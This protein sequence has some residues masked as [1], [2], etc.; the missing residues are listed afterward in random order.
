MIEDVED[1]P[2]ELEFEALRKFGVFQHRPIKLLEVSQREHVAAQS[3]CIA[4][5][6]LGKGEAG[7]VRA[8]DRGA[9]RGVHAPSAPA[10]DICGGIAPCGNC[11][12]AVERPA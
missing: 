5:Q 6:G 12:E 2:T 9:R 4:K 7:R 11:L 1:F 3:P 8:D 10:W